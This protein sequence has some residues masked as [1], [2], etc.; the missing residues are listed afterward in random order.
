MCIFTPFERNNDENE[1][2]G[3]MLDRLYALA[4]EQKNQK[5]MVTVSD[6]EDYDTKSEFQVASPW[7]MQKKKGY[8]LLSKKSQFTMKMKWKFKRKLEANWSQEKKRR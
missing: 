2:F 5:R 6:K 3:E 4:Q 8:R 7:L 1:I